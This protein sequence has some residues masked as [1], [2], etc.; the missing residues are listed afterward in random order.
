LV[1]LE[2]CCS[3][4]VQFPWSMSQ[5]GCDLLSFERGSRS[6]EVPL[7]EV[8]QYAIS[9]ILFNII[10]TSS[11]MELNS[12]VPTKA[13]QCTGILS[14]KLK[15]NPFQVQW[16]LVNGLEVLSSPIILLSVRIVYRLTRQDL[17]W[18]PL[19]DAVNPT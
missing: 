14:L 16:I 5:R 1:A 13:I 4:E 12:V 2:R 8:T 15:L 10:H 9:N 18:N 3:S 19:C 6:L 11:P 17:V 7:M